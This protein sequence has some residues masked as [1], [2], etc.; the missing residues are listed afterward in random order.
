MKL[1]LLL[2]YSTRMSQRTP[3]RQS[4][5]TPN[6]P[7]HQCEFSRLAVSSTYFLLLMMLLLLLLAFYIPP[8]LLYDFCTRLCTIDSC[9]SSSSSSAV[10]EIRVVLCRSMCPAVVSRI[11][12]IQRRI[13]QQQLCV[14]ILVYCAAVCVVSCCV[15]RFHDFKFE[16]CC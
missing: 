2:V 7:P 16:T 10:R 9:C 1:D 11:I 15:C 4:N 5:R 14:V 8:L 12:S 6:H 13:A 3:V